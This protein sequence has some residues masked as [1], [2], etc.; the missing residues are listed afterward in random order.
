MKVQKKQRPFHLGMGGGAG[1]GWFHRWGVCS[2]ADAWG[3]KTFQMRSRW[4]KAATIL[5]DGCSLMSETKS[6]WLS[7]I[8]DLVT[9]LIHSRLSTCVLLGSVSSRHRHRGSQD[10]E[11]EELVAQLVCLGMVSIWV[12]WGGAWEQEWWRWAR[13]RWGRTFAVWRRAGRRHWRM[14]QSRATCVNSPAFG[15]ILF[16][17][18]A[19]GGL[20]G[21]K[22][23]RIWQVPLESSFCCPGSAPSQRSVLILGI[24]LCREDAPATRQLTDKLSCHSNTSSTYHKEGK[25]M[26]CSVHMGKKT[27]SLTS[28]CWDQKHVWLQGVEMLQG[29]LEEEAREQVCACCVYTSLSVF[30]HTCSPHIWSPRSAA[31]THKPKHTAPHS[32]ARRDLAK[33]VAAA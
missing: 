16:S 20:R 17:K 28:G 30:I 8:P 25:K 2:R 15:Q 26:I 6:I 31:E 11:T 3:V 7:S 4:V 18:L 5:W 33:T 14:W 13:S 10:L 12:R 19:G 21:R 32:P 1:Q 9:Y 22:Q 23:A 29:R 27:R 24:K